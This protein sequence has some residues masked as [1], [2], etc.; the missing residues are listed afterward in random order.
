MCYMVCV[1]FDSIGNIRFGRN[2]CIACL[3]FSLSFC[4]QRN[5]SHDSLYCIKP[6]HTRVFFYFLLWCVNFLCVMLFFRY[7]VLL[8][9]TK[10]VRCCVTFLCC[11]VTF[12]WV[13]FRVVV[14]LF[15]MRVNFC[16]IIISTSCAFAYV[17]RF[18][19]KSKSFSHRNLKFCCNK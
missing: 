13:T 3:F 17:I 14:L 16:D 15:I 6:L 5:A 4:V 7:A 11:C 9:V 2:L 10:L 8:S 18:T 19:I 12:C 1:S